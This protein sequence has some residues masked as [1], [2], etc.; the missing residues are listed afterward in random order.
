[1]NAHL[2]SPLAHIFRRLVSGVGLRAA[3]PARSRAA[4]RAT[5]A[6]RGF[7]VRAAVVGAAPTIVK[8]EGLR[9]SPPAN[10]IHYYVRTQHTLPWAHSR[11]CYTTHHTT[12]TPLR[13]MLPQLTLTLI[14]LV[15]SW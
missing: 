15:V 2:S 13:L 3:L 14:P 12:L 7:N 11:S 8:R 1:M 9:H 10:V 6:S 5:A 4:A